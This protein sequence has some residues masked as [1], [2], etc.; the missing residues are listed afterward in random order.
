MSFLATA[1]LQCEWQNLDLCEQSLDEMIHICKKYK[2]KYIVFCG[3]GK[4]AYDPVSIRVV[5]WWQH[6]IRAARK[7]NIEVHYLMGNHDRISTYT[8]AGNWLSVLRRAGARTYDTPQVVEIRECR[9]FFLPYTSVK[10][11]KEWAKK[12][13]NHKPN[14][15]KDVLFF[16]AN[17]LEA[18][19]SQHGQN[20]DS[21]LSCADLFNSMYRFCIGGDIHFPQR[22]SEEKNVYFVGSAFCHDWG[23]VNQ[24][25]RYLVVRDEGIS[26]IHSHIPRYFDPD[27]PGF[28]ISKPEIWK[29]S[30]VRLSVPCDVSEN[31][32][33]RLEKARRRAERKYKGADIYIVP[34][35]KDD[36][37]SGVSN[38]ST[39]ASDETKIREYVKQTKLLKPLR[40]S[41]VKYMLSVLSHFAG[42][43]RTKG[44]VTFCWAKCKN[45]LPFRK[46]Y[47]DFQRK[48]IT[49]IQGINKDRNNKSNGAAKTSLMQPIPVSLFGRTFKGQSS[50]K[51]SNRW[52][53][54][55]EAFAH[56][57][58]LDEHNN[59]LDI[60]RGRRPTMLKLLVN[61]HN[62]SSGM[63]ST[64]RSGTQSRIESKVGFTWDTLANAVYID[65]AITHSFLSGTKKQRSEVLSRFQNLE[66]FEKALAYVRK[67]NKNNEEKY[68]NASN[69]LEHIRGKLEELKSSLNKLKELRR[70]QVKGAYEEYRRYKFKFKRLIKHNKARR[71]ELEKRSKRYEKAYSRATRKQEKQ[72][73]QVAVSEQRWKNAKSWNEKWE[74]LKDK[75]KCP[76]CFQPIDKTHIDK[77]RNDVYNLIKIESRRL[78]KQEKELTKLRR[79]AQ[80]LDGKYTKVQMKL[81]KIDKEESHLRI[82]KQTAR[83]QYQDL[84]S[85]QHTAYTIIGKTRKEIKKVEHKKHELK[86]YK[87]KLQKRRVLYAYA[88]QAFSRDG[89]PAFLNKQLV[90]VLNKAAQYYSELFTDG[91]IQVRVGLENGEFVPQIINTKGGE[92]I[93]DQSTGEL[94]ISG[95]IAS[96]ALREAAP[97]TNLLMLDE[98]SEGLDEQTAKQFARGLQKLKHRFKS[99]FL[100]T[101]NE[102][103]LSEFS[104]ENTITV[105]KKNG[106]SKIQEAA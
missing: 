6:A 85:R 98:P 24:R 46:L 59:K 51:W 36:E 63:K 62:E 29:G 57:R 100:C 50:D 27:V 78:K 74:L 43:L 69:K 7:S 3:D 30:R 104:R 55:E 75:D 34:K 86:Q 56:L 33:R 25:K 32:G 58:L 76:T 101:H 8:E 40:E 1:D 83:S 39:T 47:V 45:F 90:P 88:I 38:I 66:R 68:Q 94:S 96:F 20:S 67:D 89:I 77:H 23:E 31:Y 13:V 41:V 73:K 103:L 42:G 70:V 99:I 91:E 80:I 22:L 102:H 64:D 105:V 60:I 93:D 92:G 15:N 72:E 16:H 95:L 5:Q 2:L 79:K 21:K 9:L 26:S 19:Y 71:L 28:D 44:H 54:K 12:L 14:K 81:E 37:R 97:Q 10:Q 106:I 82:S 84:I 61:G 17:L 48:G 53:R 35:F 52:H 87:S 18:R 49:V 65:R 4:E 11:T